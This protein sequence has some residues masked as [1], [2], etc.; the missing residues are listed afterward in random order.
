MK[1]N[2]NCIEIIYLNFF[3]FHDKNCLKIFQAK[4]YKY[5][6]I[7]LYCPATVLLQLLPANLFI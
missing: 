2:I 1:Q 3:F 5:I 6:H 4:I 7:N